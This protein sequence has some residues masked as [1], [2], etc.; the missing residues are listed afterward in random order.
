MKKRENLRKII[1]VGVTLST[2]SAMCDIFGCCTDMHS[3]RLV[4]R[5][6][7]G[8]AGIAVGMLVGQVSSDAAFAFV[9]KVIAAYEGEELYS[10]VL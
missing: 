6:A 3:G 4:K 8:V 1:K 5:L 2:M 7:S 9:D 10:E